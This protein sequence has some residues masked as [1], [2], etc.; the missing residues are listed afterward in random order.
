[1]WIVFR[2]RSLSGDGNPY[3]CAP[4]KYTT[5]CSRLALSSAMTRSPIAR[6]CSERPSPR[7]S[8]TSFRP[9]AYRIEYCSGV[10]VW[11]A[12]DLALTVLAGVVALSIAVAGWHD[13]SQGYDVWYYHLPFAARI[14]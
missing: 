10:V 7:S 5:R 11:R 3:A 6:W 9:P 8:L 13:V 2:S 1:M 12:V 14:V 4:L